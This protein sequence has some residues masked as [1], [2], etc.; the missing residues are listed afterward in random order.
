MY[1]CVYIC[2]HHA[3]YMYMRVLFKKYISTYT[4]T[5]IKKTGDTQK[6][7]NTSDVPY[8]NC[9]VADFV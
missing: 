3:S 7:E 9:V 4:F 2:V 8:Y 5:N 1:L 6:T